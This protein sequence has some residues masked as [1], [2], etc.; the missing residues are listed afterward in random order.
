METPISVQ[1]CKSDT[2]E[3]SKLRA[4]EPAHNKST[5]ESRHPATKEMWTDKQTMVKLWHKERSKPHP[6]LI[7]KA[8]MEEKKDVF[9]RVKQKAGSG[10]A[11]VVHSTDTTLTHS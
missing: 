11:S 7:I 6:D 9:K 4:H 5:T 8:H 3:M 1:V 2:G 10:K